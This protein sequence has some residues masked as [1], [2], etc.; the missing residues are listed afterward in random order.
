M[1]TDT[2]T[3]NGPPRNHG[4]EIANAIYAHRRAEYD[5]RAVLEWEA[6]HGDEAHRVKAIKALREWGDD[7]MGEPVNGWILWTVVGGVLAGFWGPWTVGIVRIFNLL[8]TP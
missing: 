6:E 3:P 5:P 1:E 7:S 8:V 2:M 4:D